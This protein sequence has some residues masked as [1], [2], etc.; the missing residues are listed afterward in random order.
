MS[1]T[2]F[3]MCGAPGRAG[4]A[5][6]GQRGRTDRRLSLTRITP[7]G[8]ALMQEAEA[9]NRAQRAAIASRLTPQEWRQ[10]STFCERIYGNRE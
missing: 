8:L 4:R 7:K 1:P 10:L 2:G 9:A 5:S 3:F 6:L